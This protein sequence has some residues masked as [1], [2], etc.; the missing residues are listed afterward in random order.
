LTDSSLYLVLHP[1][2]CLI[3]FQNLTWDLSLVHCAPKLLEH[4][5]ETYHTNSPSA[6]ATTSKSLSELDSIFMNAILSMTPDQ[7]QVLVTELK[8]YFNGTCPCPDRN[9][10][11][12]WMVCIAAPPYFISLI[13][14]AATCCRVSN[15][16]S[17]CP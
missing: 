17:Y 7:Q 11:K 4:L 6:K 13:L 10:F 8:A 14:I 5:Y 2:I 12:W 1:S 15:T 9:V 3:F 16:L